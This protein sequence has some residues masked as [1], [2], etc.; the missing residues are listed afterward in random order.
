MTTKCKVIQRPKRNRPV[1]AAA[2]KK[3]ATDGLKKRMLPFYTVNRITWPPSA[4]LKGRVEVGFE[5]NTSLQPWRMFSAPDIEWFLKPDHARTDNPEPLNSHAW[6]RPLS[7][8]FLLARFFQLVQ[9]FERETGELLPYGEQCVREFNGAMFPLFG[10][11]QFGLAMLVFLKRFLKRVRVDHNSYADQLSYFDLNLTA[12]WITTTETFVS[13][14][15]VI[16]R[17]PV[18][19]LSFDAQ[20]HPKP[21][22][23]Y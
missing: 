19:Q 8:F 3:V 11:P 2:L 20:G 4:N 22:Y 17:D 7:D 6:S 5:L 15:V 14:T 13:K 23:I 21:T 1:I 9:Y 12:T 18:D 10:R 16:H